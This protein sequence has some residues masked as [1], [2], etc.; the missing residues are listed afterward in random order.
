MLTLRL[1]L[2]FDFVDDARSFPTDKN[3]NPTATPTRTRWSPTEQNQ[4]TSA[5]IRSV[6]NRW[7]YRYPI[8]AGKPDCLWATTICDR[9]LA[10][11]EVIPVT[12]GGDAIVHVAHIPS[13]GYRSRVNSGNAYLTQ[14]DVV[15]GSNLPSQVTVDHEFGHLLGLEHS[16]PACQITAPVPEKDT[17]SDKCYGVT[18]EQIADVM[19]KGSIVTPQDYRPFVEEMNYYAT[20]C[21]WKTEG[22][23]PKPGGSFLSGHAGLAVGGLLGAA[24]GAAL[25]GVSGAQGPLGG[26]AGAVIGGLLGAAGGAAVGAIAD[27]IAS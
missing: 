18:A 17:N 22:T 14:E 6:S 4:W 8:V 16:N 15:P 3:R 19:G 2:S 7:S 25:G 26:V 5:F 9:A 20:G 27:L 11:V 12:S 13:S 10:R 23:A 1:N 24:G 21:D